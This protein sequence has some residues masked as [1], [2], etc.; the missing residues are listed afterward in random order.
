M[1]VHL[2]QRLVPLPSDL[3]TF[4]H[5][6]CQPWTVAAE[7]CSRRTAP[8]LSLS[9]RMCGRNFPAGRQ[10]VAHRQV[11]SQRPLGHQASRFL[12]RFHVPGLGFVL[13]AVPIWCLGPSAIMLRPAPG[14]DAGTRFPEIVFVK[15]ATSL[16]MSAN[17]RA[18]TA[19]LPCPRVTAEE[20][21]LEPVSCERAGLQLHLCWQHGRGRMIVLRDHERRKTR[22]GADLR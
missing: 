8:A 4:S 12:N 7:H 1:L 19:P 6:A 18:T 16:S 14:R 21:D 3:P 15:P 9:N 2:V 11:A 20:T 5:C 13:L 17:P 22:K 10:K